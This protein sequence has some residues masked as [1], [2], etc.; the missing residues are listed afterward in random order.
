MK[1]AGDGLTCTRNQQLHGHGPCGIHE[2]Q[3]TAS[4]PDGISF[5]HFAGFSFS[6]TNFGLVGMKRR[7]QQ[8]TSTTSLLHISHSQMESM[9]SPMSHVSDVYEPDFDTMEGPALDQSGEE[10][11]DRSPYHSDARVPPSGSSSSSSTDAHIRLAR[12]AQRYDR[13]MRVLPT[14]IP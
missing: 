8:L 14:R 1:C 13:L 6:T 9:P 4:V 11:Q 3:Y 12:E 7:T 2:C 5:A 10:N